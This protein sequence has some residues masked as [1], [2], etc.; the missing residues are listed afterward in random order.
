MSTSPEAASPKLRSTL[1]LALA[2]SSTCQLAGYSCPG[3]VH[4]MSATRVSTGR[5]FCADYSLP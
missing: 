4:D 3:H 2:R 5:G 1:A